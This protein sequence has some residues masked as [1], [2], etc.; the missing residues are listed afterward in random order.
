MLIARV[1][2]NEPDALLLDEPTNHLDLGKIIQLERWLQWRH[3]QHAGDHRQPRSR[4][5]RR[6]RPTGRC[7]CGPARRTISRCRSPAP[8]PRWPR[9]TRPPPSSRR[10]TSRKP[11]SSASRRPSSPISASIRARD[12]LTLKAKYLKERAAKIE[13]AAVRAPQGA[14]RRDPARQHRHACQGAGRHRGLDGPHAGWPRRCS[15]SP[16]CICSRATA[17]CCSAATAPASRSS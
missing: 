3:P 9:P 10:R 16:S 17:S 7:S 1:W 8:A 12:L 13:A 6:R 5:P 2:V 4:L 14:L 11:S 15:R